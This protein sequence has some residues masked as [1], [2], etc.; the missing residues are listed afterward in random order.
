LIVYISFIYRNS[1]SQEKRHADK[2]EPHQYSHQEQ[3][4]RT[5]RKQS[6]QPGSYNERLA[7]G[8]AL[9]LTVHQL[10]T[11]NRRWH[12]NRRITMRGKTRRPAQRR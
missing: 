5:V 12:S 6:E 11:P 10:S 2:N 4:V 9:R 1:N 7:N 3:D 8:T